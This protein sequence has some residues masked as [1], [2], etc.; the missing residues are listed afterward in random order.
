MNELS[1]AEI[2]YL[3]GFF[4]ADGCVNIT[5]SKIKQRK[6]PRH[7]L[8]VVFAQSDKPFLEDLKQL[9]GIGGVYR[10][11]DIEFQTKTRYSWHMTGKQAAGI[12]SAMLPHLRVKRKQAELGLALQATKAVNYRRKGTP[13][14]VLEERDRILEQFR[15]TRQF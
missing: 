13:D 3:A 5:K 11:P 6:T 4:D 15:A 14:P 1:E 7:Q 2:A 10:L 12:L 9:T 8:Q